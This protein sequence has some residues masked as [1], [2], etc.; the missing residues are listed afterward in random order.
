M[1]QIIYGTD[2]LLGQAITIHYIYIT[3]VNVYGNSIR[4]NRPN[5]KVYNT[6]NRIEHRAREWL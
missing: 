1:I 5:T 6:F 4:L 3:F 2:I